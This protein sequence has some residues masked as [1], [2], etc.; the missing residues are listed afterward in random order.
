MTIEYLLPCTCGEKLAVDRSQA[1]LSVRCRCGAELAVPTL[2]GLAALERAPA[3]AEPSQE[4]G[5]RQALWLAGGWVAALGVL[6]VVVLWLMAPRYP[7]SQIDEQLEIVRRAAD[8]EAMTP[9]QALDLW[10]ALAEGLNRQTPPG[11]V[12]YGEA[13]VIY[14]SRMRMALVVAGAGL[15]LLGAAFL[16]PKPGPARSP[17]P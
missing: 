3:E 9:K 1:G 13:A 15:V 10:N 12:A 14:R 6:A 5:P 7:Q 4:W 2:R 16:V 8:I 11:I 17:R